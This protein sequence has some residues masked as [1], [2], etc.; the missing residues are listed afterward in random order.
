MFKIEAGEKSDLRLLLQFG[1]QELIEAWTRKVYNRLTSQPI[2]PFESHHLLRDIVW[3]LARDLGCFWFN[4]YNDGMQVENLPHNI[5]GDTGNNPTTSS[6]NL[7]DYAIQTGNLSLSRELLVSKDYSADEIA[8]I[9]LLKPRAK[10]QLEFKGKNSH[11]TSEFLK[12]W[13]CYRHYPTNQSKCIDYSPDI[14]LEF[15][16]FDQL[17]VGSDYSNLSKVEWRKVVARRLAESDNLFDVIVWHTRMRKNIDTNQFLLLGWLNWKNQSELKQLLVSIYFA[18]D[19]PKDFIK[20]RAATEN[21]G[22][23]K[24]IRIGLFTPFSSSESNVGRNNRLLH[25]NLN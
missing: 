22:K 20:Q 24:K 6:L 17:P 5:I 10:F 8:T 18:A 12:S 21:V 7:L 25:S 23:R 3:C 2:P 11:G 15:Q 14:L 16:D 1:T 9:V 4:V 13:L 19:N